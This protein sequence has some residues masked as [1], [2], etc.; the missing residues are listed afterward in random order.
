VVLEDL[1]WLW[2]SPDHQGASSTIIP[3][4]SLGRVHPFG[5]FPSATNNVRPALGGAAARRR[6]GMEVEDKGHLKDF[7]FVEVLSTI[8]YFF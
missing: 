5:D 4:S 8:R 1:F 2:E 7:V 3:S 6:Q